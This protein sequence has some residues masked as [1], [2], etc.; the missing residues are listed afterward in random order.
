MRFFEF[1]RIWAAHLAQLNNL[2]EDRQAEMA[3]AIQII[4]ITVI[5][6]IL[7]LAWGAILGVLY[8]TAFCLF[9]VAAFRHNAGGGHSQSPYRCALITMIVFPLLALTAHYIIL[10]H[11]Q[12]SYV[13]TATS[14]I[15]GFTSI[16]RY[17]PASNTK[18]PPLSS[19]RRN[20][21]KIYALIIMFFLSLFILG[22]NQS[23]W[24]MAAEMGLCITLSIL[25]VSFNLTKPA[26][27]L[28]QLIDN[29][30]K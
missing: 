16:L 10:N 12:Y 15:L 7:T 5:D 25:W 14:I 29:L 4:V 6:A 2:D 13:L 11:F 27:R 30:G 21:L 26:N 19:N 28:W 8:G 9:T 17:A 1:S 20:K 3:Y 23:S 18:A 22:L 24:D